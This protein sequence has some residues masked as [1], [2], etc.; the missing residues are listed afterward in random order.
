MTLFTHQFHFVLEGNNIFINLSSLNCRQRCLFSD[1]EKFSSKEQNKNESELLNPDDEILNDAESFP[2]QKVL[3][4]SNKGEMES[5][6]HNGEIN[7]N[8]WELKIN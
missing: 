2:Y 6:V 7:G 3:K 1:I 8:F 5:K 4:E